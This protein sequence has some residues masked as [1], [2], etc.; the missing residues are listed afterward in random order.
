MIRS[1]DGADFGDYV[2]GSV[3]LRHIGVLGARL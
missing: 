3:V 1:Q 2:P